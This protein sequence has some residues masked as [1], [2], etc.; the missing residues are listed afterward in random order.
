MAKSSQYS[1]KEAST[2]ELE[3]LTER[4]TL[5]LRSSIR[6]LVGNAHVL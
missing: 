3:R 4:L 5:E 1:A 6:Q 2:D